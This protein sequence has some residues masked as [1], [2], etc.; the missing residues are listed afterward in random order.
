MRQIGHT[1]CIA[2]VCH[3]C[4]NF[5]DF[6]VI[7]RLIS[8]LL[9]LDLMHPSL[10]RIALFDGRCMPKRAGRVDRRD[11]PVPFR[12]ANQSIKTQALRSRAVDRRACAV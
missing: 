6:A 7:G 5:T 2:G 4:T 10:V 3:A 12:H 1:Q 11:C 9:P 8:I